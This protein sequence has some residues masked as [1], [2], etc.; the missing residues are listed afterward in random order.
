MKSQKTQPIYY[1]K[2]NKFFL[3]GDHDG[4]VFATGGEVE[5]T[6]VSKRFMQFEKAMNYLSN[7]NKKNILFKWNIFFLSCTFSVWI[8]YCQD[9]LYDI[10]M[11][12]NFIT[13]QI[14][15][16]LNYNK[17]FVQKSLCIL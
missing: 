11:L 8:F 14:R 3:Y 7:K 6:R 16:F 10:F 9:V 13:F 2:V 4:D 17:C 5:I 12:Y 15:T 1:G